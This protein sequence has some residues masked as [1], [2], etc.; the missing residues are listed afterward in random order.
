MALENTVERM[1]T[2]SIFARNALKTAHNVLHRYIAGSSLLSN[3]LRV[4]SKLGFTSD[5]RHP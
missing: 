3:P 4:I 2:A 5:L 1:G